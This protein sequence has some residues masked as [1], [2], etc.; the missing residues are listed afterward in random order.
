MEA[1]AFERTLG[2]FTRRKPFRPFMVELVSGASLLVEHPE[3]LIIRG[4]VA[5]HI[6]KDNEWTM[7][8][9]EGVSRI[10]TR[11]GAATTE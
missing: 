3:A 8:D 7:F 10:T 2:V 4:A 1:R 11:K 6:D 5:I 9:N